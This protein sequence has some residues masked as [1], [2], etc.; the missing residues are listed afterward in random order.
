MDEFKGSR[1][2]AVIEGGSEVADGSAK[3]TRDQLRLVAARTEMMERVWGQPFKLGFAH[4][5]LTSTTLPYRNPGDDVR[6]ITRTSGSGSLLIEAGVIPSADGGFVDVGIPY[7]SLSRLILLNICSEAVRTNSPVIPIKDSFTRFARNLGISVNGR[8]LKRLREQINRMSGVSI[9]LSKHHNGVADVFQGPIFSQ[10]RAELP[11]DERQRTFWTSVVELN[12]KFYES[13]RSHAVPLD[14]TA[15]AA[16]S[17]NARALDVLMWLSARLWRVHPSKPVTL[18][19]TT[20]RWSF[21]NP[22][23]RMKSFKTRFNQALQKALYVY[24]EANVRVVHGGVEL[25]HSP[26]PVAFKRTKLLGDY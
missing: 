9:R 15:I 4:S 7:G 2:L 17:N 3:L 19:W 6:R 8:S 25:R 16:V 22:D 11:E 26:P 12:P 24:P 23:Q 10:F 18:K 20:L 13:L 1:S 21:G 5:F 14:M